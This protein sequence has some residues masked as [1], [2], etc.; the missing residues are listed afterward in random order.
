M[1]SGGMFILKGILGVIFGL[2]LILVPKFALGTFVTLFGLFIIAAGII[3]FLFAVT[4]QQTDTLFWFL[5]SGGIII[6]GIVAIWN[7]VLF[8]SI[9]G[10][11]VAGWALITGFL[12][13]E[14]Y[15]QSSRRFYAIVAV[16]S[17]ISIVLILATFY[18]LPSFY[19]DYISRVF[20]FYALVFGIFSLILGEMI[21]RGKV[22]RYLQPARPQ[23]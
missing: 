22:A 9:F 4:S 23:E 11:C 7:S 3:T 15:I 18:L 21:I 8:A 1:Y 14:K 19:E 6:L 20:G 13:L 12:D 17:G 10:I 16:L 5:L 2:L